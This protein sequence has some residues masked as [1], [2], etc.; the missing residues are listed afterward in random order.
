MST[1]DAMGTAGTGEKV[2]D[3]RVLA[4]RLGEHAGRWVAVRGSEVVADDSTLDGLRQQVAGKDVDRI[5][6]VPS[7]KVRL[8]L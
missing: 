5:F 2:R 1:A 3:Q 7:R 4:G 8:L 6:R